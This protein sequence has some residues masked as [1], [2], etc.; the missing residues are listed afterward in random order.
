MIFLKW[1]AVDCEIA[2]NRWAIVNG[3]P[4]YRN[5]NNDSYLI[6]RFNTGHQFER[7][8]RSCF[9][10]HFSQRKSTASHRKFF[11]DIRIENDCAAIRVR[12][13]TDRFRYRWLG[14]L[15]VTQLIFK[16]ELLK[17]IYFDDS[18]VKW[19]FFYYFI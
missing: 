7:F 1:I 16:T 12:F 2:S 8:C 10:F 14:H 5:G 15:E 9:L 6:T 11:C 18:S 17:Q 3:P 13:F 4:G 19:Y